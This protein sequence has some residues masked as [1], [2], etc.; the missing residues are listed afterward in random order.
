M[1]AAGYGEAGKSILGYMLESYD[2]EGFF[3]RLSEMGDA[4]FL[5]T[6]VIFNHMGK[7]FST[8][9]RFHSDMLEAES[10]EDRWLGEFTNGAREAKIPVVLGGHSL[11][12]GGMLALI[13]AAW[14]DSRE[15]P[16][17]CTQAVG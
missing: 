6:R 2:I 3:N 14:G 17:D 9:D 10:I 8:A 12:S 5:D 4:A 7:P 11:V 15:D 1:R 16:I 13:D